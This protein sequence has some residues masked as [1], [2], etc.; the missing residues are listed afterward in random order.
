MMKTYGINMT[1][2]NLIDFTKDNYHLKQGSLYEKIKIR[3]V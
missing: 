1:F 3:E 2:I